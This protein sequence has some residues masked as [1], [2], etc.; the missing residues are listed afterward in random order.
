M[1]K[2]LLNILYYGLIVFALIQF[3]PVDRNNPP[4]RVSEDFVHVMKTPKEVRTVLRTSCYDCHSNETIYPNAAYVAPI[5]WSIKHNVNKARTHL[6]FSTWETANQD[7]KADRLENS[8]EVVKASKMP[9]AG[10]VAQHPQARLD[11]RQ[12][13]LLVDYFEGILEQMP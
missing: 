10:Y 2:T 3:I 12:R 4:V 6:N 8:I 11:A 7:L 13:Q 1:K 5:S 9:I